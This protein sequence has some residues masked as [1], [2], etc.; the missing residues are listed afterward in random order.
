MGF[1]Y[2]ISNYFSASLTSNLATETSSIKTFSDLEKSELAVYADKRLPVV[3]A[4][5]EV[6]LNMIYFC[7]SKNNSLPIFFRV[8]TTEGSGKVATKFL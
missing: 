2:L 7:I 5:V 6:S 3:N 4:I 8:F 1:A